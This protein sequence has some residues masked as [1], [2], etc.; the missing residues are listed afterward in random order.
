MKSII[1]FFEND[2]FGTIRT[3]T[4]KGGNPWFVG[5]DVAGIL[6]YSNP[7]KSIRDRVFEEDKILVQLAETQRGLNCPPPVQARLT[8]W[9]STRVGFT[10]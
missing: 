5:K 7:T 3:L 9:L 4:G 8:S 6:G 1:K 2:E 10:A